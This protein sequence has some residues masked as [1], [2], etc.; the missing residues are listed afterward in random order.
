MKLRPANTSND[1]G[2]KLKDNNSAQLILIFAKHIFE[3]WRSPT[4]G[5]KLIKIVIVQIVVSLVAA[6]GWWI[7]KK[8][9][10]NAVMSLSLG[11][12]VCWVPSAL[13]AVLL[14]KKRH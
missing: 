6:L 8:S 10:G 13:F 3:F 5:V 14:R 1:H 7:F 9:P 12:L 2:D 11:G 4:L